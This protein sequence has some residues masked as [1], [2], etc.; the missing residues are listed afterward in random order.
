VGTPFRSEDYPSPLADQ[1]ILPRRVH[2]AR[3]SQ[4]PPRPSAGPPPAPPTCRR[5]PEPDR[6][7]GV[8]SPPA[9]HDLRIV[10]R[11]SGKTLVFVMSSDVWA[12]EARGRLVFVHAPQGCFDIDLPLIEVESVLGPTFCRV[13][14]NWLVDLSKVRE[15]SSGNGAMHLFAG[16]ALCAESA[17][18]R[19]VEVPVARDRVKR[20]RRQLLA[21]TFG[22][23][24]AT[25]GLG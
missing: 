13:H 6:A 14:R 21:D 8:L 16:M 23:R 1:G 15:L 2:E 10:A 11:S 7:S 9:G 3:A 22:L 25:R 18:R 19:G 24:P 12:F 4:I 5:L 17:V 20:V